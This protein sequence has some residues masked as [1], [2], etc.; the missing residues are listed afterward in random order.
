[1]AHESVRVD[2]SR[3][4]MAML[5]LNRPVKLDALSLAQGLLLEAKRSADHNAKV[6]PAAIAARRR[7]LP[8]PK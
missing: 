1:M 8:H 3:P 4:G 7:D 5:T 6:T 2:R